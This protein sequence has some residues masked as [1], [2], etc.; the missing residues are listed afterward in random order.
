VFQCP[1]QPSV[2]EACRSLIKFSGVVTDKIRQYLSGN[3]NRPSNVI[4][5]MTDI[6]STSGRIHSEFVY[7]LI[8]KT[9]STETSYQQGFIVGKLGSGMRCCKLNSTSNVLVCETQRKVYMY[10]SVSE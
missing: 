8:N 1:E 7:L 10:G 5:F 3:N 9:L 4:S 6:P 2:C